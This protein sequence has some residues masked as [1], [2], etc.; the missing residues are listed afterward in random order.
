M[1][2]VAAPIVAEGGGRADRVA[3]RLASAGNGA[4]CAASP[5]AR[6]MSASPL[7]PADN[8]S[9]IV[10]VRRLLA[11]AD[12]ATTATHSDTDIVDPRKNGVTQDRRENHTVDKQE[13]TSRP[14]A[15]TVDKN[16][17]SLERRQRA[18]MPTDIYVECCRSGARRE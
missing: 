11:T 5:V 12:A 9:L 4:G 17:S 15:R 14:N 2:A 13:Q 8:T 1:R 6:S 10:P 16:E 3:R 7:A 18:Q